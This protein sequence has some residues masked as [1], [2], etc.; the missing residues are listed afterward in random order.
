MFMHE[1]SLQKKE[2]EGYTVAYFDF[3]Q[4]SSFFERAHGS[5]PKGALRANP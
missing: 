3:T 4:Y 1:N 5:L 2:F